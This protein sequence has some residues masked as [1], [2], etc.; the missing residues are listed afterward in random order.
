MSTWSTRSPL[1]WCHWSLI[2]LIFCSGCVAV[3]TTAGQNFVYRQSV[4][5]PLLLGICGLGLAIGG[6]LA[7]IN[8]IPFLMPAKPVKKKGK[9]RKATPV[10]AVIQLG[11]ASM[12][13]MLGM[14]LLLMGVPSTLLSTVTVQPDRIVLRTGNMFYSTSSRE[15][16][17]ESIEESQVVEQQTLGSKGRRK[18]KSY[19]IIAHSGGQ[20]RIE[21]NPMHLA[22]QPK[23]AAFLNAFRQL[24]EDGESGNEP[25]LAATTESNL[26]AASSIPMAT[27]TAVPANE[28]IATPKLPTEQAN[29]PAQNRSNEVSPIEPGLTVLPQRGRFR[30][31]KAVG[32]TQNGKWVEGKVDQVFTQDKVSIRP[33]SDPNQVIL[34]PMSSAM[35]SALG[36]AAPVLPGDEI[37]ATSEVKIGDTIM[38]VWGAYWYPVRVEGFGMERYLRLSFIGEPNVGRFEAPISQICR[39]P[40]NGDLLVK[41][42]MGEP[43]DVEFP[44]ADGHAEDPMLLANKFKVDQIVMARF[45]GNS[46]PAQILVIRDTGMIRVHYLDFENRFDAD[47]PADQIR[48]MTP[49]EIQK[50]KSKNRKN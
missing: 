18:T 15:I 25:A 32:F 30:A 37:K 13:T 41:A 34:V 21:M 4:L 29:V 27:T 35:I 44:R 10:R 40:K 33:N 5:V 22:A 6:V 49:K 23:F 1:G 46:I 39:L 19:W 11:F 16:P 12:M 2:P 43:V 3:E 45:G 24:H 28:P 42:A 48:E 31:G 36:V 47:L 8:A 20:E 9:K 26:P 17:Y 38:A 7:A 50:M 14:G